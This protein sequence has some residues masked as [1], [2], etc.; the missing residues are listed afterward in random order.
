[1]SLSFR[2]TRLEAEVRGMWPY[3]EQKGD[4]PPSRPPGHTSR[5]RP[6]V[7]LQLLRARGQS[8]LLAGQ[9]WP[10]RGTLLRCSTSR[11]GCTV[12]EDVSPEELPRLL[13]GERMPDARQSPRTFSIPRLG[14]TEIA[15]PGTEGPRPGRQGR[16][17]HPIAGHDRLAADCV[18]APRRRA[19]SKTSLLL[20]RSANRT[21]RSSERP[22]PNSLSSWSVIADPVSPRRPGRSSSPDLPIGT[23]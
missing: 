5:T 16:R 22:S 15:L 23:A 14:T 13:Q 11:F 2:S 7:G 10:R 12:S 17:P 19:R 9:R 18:A 3:T 6:S 20:S 21:H 1:M 4:G 8:S